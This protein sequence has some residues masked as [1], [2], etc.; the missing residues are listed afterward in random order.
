MEV[1]DCSANRLSAHNHFDLQSV[2]FPIHPY[3]LQPPTPLLLAHGFMA[4]DVISLRGWGAFIK[5]DG[6][7]LRDGCR[8]WIGS[9]SR[10]VGSTFERRMGD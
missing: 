1:D 3:P 9:H 2:H 8:D 6:V 5:Y 10:W 4:D 7:Y